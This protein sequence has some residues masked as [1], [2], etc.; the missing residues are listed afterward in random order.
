[1]VTATVRQK[2]SLRDL[3]T[4]FINRPNLSERTRESYA[5]L[6][7]N[8]EGYARAK[9]FPGPQDITREHVR[10]F[11]DYVATEGYRWPWGRTT[12]KKAA[13][14]TVHHY[15]KAL[16]TFF[17]WAVDEDYLD[18]SPLVR[19]KLGSPPYKEVE[20][21]SDDE[22]YAM[23]R[24]CED[25]IRFRLAYLG[26]RNKAIISLFVATGLRLEE[27]TEI[28]LPDFDPKLQQVQV[29]GK[30]SKKRVVPVNGEA[31][32]ALRRYIQVRPAGGDALWNTESG[33]P[34]SRH[35]MKIM[36]ARL[37]IRAGIT[38]G[39]GAH[40]LRHYFATRYLEAGGDLNSLRLLL[41]W[42][43]LMFVGGVVFGYFVL[44]PPAIK[45][46]TTFGANIATPQIR[47]GNYISV[48]SRLLLAI[49]LI[50]EMPVISTFLAR[51]GILKPQW[52]SGKRKFAIVG[53]FILGAVI[54]PT[55]DPINQ[56]LVALP[57]ILLYEMSIWLAR[58]VQ[59]R[60]SRKAVVMA[61][62]SR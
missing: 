43:C 51:F 35:S 38:S 16:K 32:K 10:E 26:I 47:I 44:I 36:I 6:L 53:A 23:L 25:D 45:I 28:R 1:M 56:T 46:L 15:G 58:L 61:A 24:V 20:P 60:E 48:I 42:V 2:T 29:M 31:K 52:L 8:F 59:P 7:G 33:E 40:R 37:K 12:S 39:G 34:M 5:N 19:L 27:L 21:Y 3:I 30:G 57:L 11:L 41:P 17:S 9:A 54:T 4:R 22:V 55:F 18:D 49:G 13:P 50:F 14:A 62:V